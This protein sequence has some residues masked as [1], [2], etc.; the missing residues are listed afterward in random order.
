M[1]RIV[2]L[3]AYLLMISC[4]FACGGQ[5]L[6][7]KEELITVNSKF[8]NNKS[9]SIRLNIGSLESSQDGVYHFTARESVEELFNILKTNESFYDYD[10]SHIRFLNNGNFY[11]IELYSKEKNYYEYKLY[12]EYVLLRIDESF[13]FISFPRILNDLVATKELQLSTDKAIYLEA[14]LS[15]CSNVTKINNKYIINNV[16]NIKEQYQ[17]NIE[18]IKENDKFIFSECQS[19]E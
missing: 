18:V 13:Y 6:V 12:S 16:K 15:L 3:V 5:K 9:F 1:K 17:T 7:V 8:E 2:F 11:V 19:N 10:S 14:Y 4:L